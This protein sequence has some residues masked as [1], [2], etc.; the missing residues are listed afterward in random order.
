MPGL[1]VGIDLAHHF[2]HRHRITAQGPVVRKKHGSRT[3]VSAST[4][5]AADGGP[6]ETLSRSDD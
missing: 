3:L 2:M 5:M 4:S 1:T 6:S